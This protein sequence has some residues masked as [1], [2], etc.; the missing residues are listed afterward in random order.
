MSPRRLNGQRVP[1]QAT[2]KAILQLMATPGEARRGLG[3]HH[4]CLQ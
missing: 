2:P 4:L 3:L 1:L